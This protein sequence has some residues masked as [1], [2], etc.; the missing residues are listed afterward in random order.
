MGF[1][2]ARAVLQ[3]A[4]PGSG[5]RNHAANAHKPAR[6]SWCPVAGP[7]PSGPAP[8]GPADLPAEFHLYIY[9]RFIRVGLNAAGR[10]SCPCGPGRCLVSYDVW[11]SVTDP[12]S[13][14][15]G[16]LKLSLELLRICPLPSIALLLAVH[17]AQLL[18]ESRHLLNGGFDHQAKLVQSLPV[19]L[20]GCAASR[21]PGH[22]AEY[23]A[24]I[25]VTLLGWFV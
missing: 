11:L 13:S 21:N 4:R 19:G 1:G 12:T 7:G 24:V 14:L 16:P 17:S 5:G 9:H 22:Y 8:P 6:Q 18:L 2:R 25:I 3:T 10:A 20:I 15:P 23:G